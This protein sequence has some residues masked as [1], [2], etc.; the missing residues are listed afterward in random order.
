MTDTINGMRHC[1]DFINDP[2]A[3]LALRWFLFVNRL[4]AVDRLLLKEVVPSEYS[5]PRLFAD[6]IAPNNAGRRPI[7]R[8]VMASRFGDVGITKQLDC[9]YGY[10]ERVAVEELTNFRSK[11]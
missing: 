11:P 6:R 5:A 8:V 2:S 10:S 7:V 4:S 9:E 1:D 3:P